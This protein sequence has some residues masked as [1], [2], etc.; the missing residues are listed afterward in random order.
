MTDTTP[1]TEQ[2]EQEG[3]PPTV[4]LITDL[5]A[6]IQAISERVGVL[7]LIKGEDEEPSEDGLDEE[8]IAFL[9]EAEEA[10]DFAIHVIGFGNDFQRMAA[11]A[12]IDALLGCDDELCDDC[13][14][15]AMN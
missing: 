10:L 15:K 12:R 6:S 14:K 7:D 2:T 4:A 13:R 9:K 11:I 8:E 1:E 3:F 5:A